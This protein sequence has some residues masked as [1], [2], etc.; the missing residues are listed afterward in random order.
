MPAGG[1][2]PVDGL[3]LTVGPGQIV[4][5]VG[6]SGS[7]KSLTALAITGLLPPGARIT[8][9]H[10]TLDDEDLAG[11]SDRRMN[12][13]RGNRVAMLFQQPK[14]TLDPTATVCGQVAEPLWLHRGLSCRQARARV[15]GLLRDVGIADPERVAGSYPHQLSG[16]M[17]QRV[18]I[19]AA[20][21]GDPGLLIADEPTTALDVTVQAQILALL[22]RKQRERGLSVLLITHDL[23]IVASLADRVAVMYAG[24]IVEDGTAREIFADPRHPYTKALLR[25]SLLRS[26]DG[27]LYSIAGSTAQSRSLDHGC[28]FRPRCSVAEELG[29]SRECENA[30]PTLHSCGDDHNSRCWAPPTPDAHERM[31]GV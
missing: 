30:E 17:A 25:A 24:R 19:A 11:C 15:A 5:L 6:E 8:A 9:G 7:G 4:A 22:R 31:A 20:L 28:R 16:G 23:G 14:A 1:T 12:H 26:E 3:D 13:I 10:V 2:P 27:R 21:A 18:M 29:I